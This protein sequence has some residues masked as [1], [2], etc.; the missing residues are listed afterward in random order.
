MKELNDKMLQEVSAGLPSYMNAP[1]EGQA[2]LIVQ[3]SDVVCRHCKKPATEW[4][5]Q[6]GPRRAG[7]AFEYTFQ[8]GCEGIRGRHDAIYWTDE[9][10]WSVF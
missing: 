4:V 1:T 2:K 7:S 6:F 10:T 3:E 8:C 9:N 5:F